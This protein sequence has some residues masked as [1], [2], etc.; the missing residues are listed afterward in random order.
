MMH[1]FSHVVCTAAA[2][3]TAPDSNV[4]HLYQQQS[5][6][7]RYASRV[8]C[9]ASALGARNAILQEPSLQPSF[10]MGPMRFTAIYDAS[11]RITRRAPAQHSGGERRIA[12]EEGGLPP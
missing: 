6:F 12:F 3:T 10:R 11:M 2:N 4:S 1:P 9:G 7:Q 8:S 5:S